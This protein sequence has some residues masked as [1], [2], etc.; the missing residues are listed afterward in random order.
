M[1]DLTVFSKDVLPVYTTDTGEKVVIGRELHE[2]LKIETPYTQW[3]ERMCGYG[4]S[5]NE[6]FTG[7][8]QKSE[9]PLGGRP[10]ADHILKL[11]M[12]K[13]IAMI[14]RSP[15]GKAIRDKLIS[16]ETNISQLSPEL[17][18]LISIETRQREQARQIEQVNQRLDSIGE[19]V[20]LSPTGWRNDVSKLIVNIANKMG[21]LEYIQTV[22]KEAYGLLEERAG[23][24]LETRLTNRRRRMAEEGVCKSKRDR[25]TK[26]DVIA[27]DKKLI[28]IYLA[29]VKEMA[30]KYGVTL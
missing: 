7:F 4:F 28:E 27:E 22:H 5:E 14:Q 17:R 10:T 2:A 11:D 24:R 23:T 13:H 16:L 25:L 30:V 12:A 15:E 21:G 6:D 19:V 3:F 1:N 20:A 9:K 29:I 8:S 18:A 26:M